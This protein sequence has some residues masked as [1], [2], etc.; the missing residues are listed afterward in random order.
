MVLMSEINVRSYFFYIK[1]RNINKSRKFNK[2]RIK[3]DFVKEEMTPYRMI[4]SY[5]KEIRKEKEH[6]VEIISQRKDLLESIAYE[7][8]VNKIIQALKEERKFVDSATYQSTIKVVVETYKQMFSSIKYHKRKRETYE[9]ANM[10]QYLLSLWRS[11]KEECILAITSEMLYYEEDSY[12]Y[13]KLERYARILNNDITLFPMIKKIQ[14]VWIRKHSTYK[15]KSLTFRVTNKLAGRENFIKFLDD[16]RIEINFQ[17][18]NIGRIRLISKYNRKYHGDFSD[19]KDT[20]S[21]KILKNGFKEKSYHTYILKFLENGDLKLIVTKELDNLVMTNYLKIPDTK[22]EIIGIDVNL[23]DNRMI[24]S[25]NFIILVPEDL[26]K[27]EDRLA[28]KIALH[29]RNCDRYRISKDRGKQLRLDE[30]KQE[31]RRKVKLDKDVSDILKHERLSGTKMIVLEDINANSI[32]GYKSESS[33]HENI[34]NKTIQ[35]ALL[36][37]DVKNIFIRMAHKYGLSIALVNPKYTSQEC[38]HCHTILKENRNVGYYSC[39]CGYSGNADLNAA[40]NIRNRMSNP[41]K[42]EK[43][44]Y[45]GKRNNVLLWLGKDFK[46]KKSFEIN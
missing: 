13:R 4:L 32:K 26:I 2:I 21:G 41:L 45:R 8:N 18:P 29:D 20:K 15:P 38:S 14:N 30:A 40:I 24:T 9:S 11:T 31:R 7:G 23:R 19:Y 35:R 27:H 12:N 22:S 3:T 10:K 25:N 37:D 17:L 34:R 44:Q 46:N 42:R 1:K 43:L 39:S 36:I 16:K 28:K 33:I 5:A 6:L